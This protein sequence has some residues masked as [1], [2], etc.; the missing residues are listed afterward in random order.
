MP[1][2]GVIQSPVLV[3]RDDLLDLCE[4]R[5]SQAAGNG[6]LVLVAG[7]AGIGNTRLRKL[8]GDQ[9]LEQRAVAPQ[10]LAKVL[11]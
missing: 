11:G 6:R 1:A 7:E 4:Q 10:A 3:G 8:G 5:L 2:R 9:P